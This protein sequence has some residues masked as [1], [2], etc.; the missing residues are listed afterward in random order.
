MQ[1]AQSSV[2]P[3]TDGKGK[4]RAVTFDQ[5]YP[6]WSQRSSALSDEASRHLPAGSGTSAQTP[7]F[8][9][10]PYPLF[11]TRGSGSRLRDADEHEYVDYLLGGGPMILGHRHPAVTQA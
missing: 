3:A 1:N 10:R 7:K 6:A 8:G 4:H 5:R 9:W 2:L 11:M